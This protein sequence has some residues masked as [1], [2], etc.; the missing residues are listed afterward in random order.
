V[1]SCGG[2]SGNRMRTAD[3]DTITNA[4]CGV[5]Y[6]IGC[7]T[8]AFDS[9]SIAEAFVTNSHGGT[10]A[11]IGNS[12]YGWGSPG[13]PGFGYS[14]KFDNRFW[15]ALTS[16]GRYRVGDA[17]T[18]AKAYYAPFS[19]DKNVYRW[20]QYEVNLMGDP[21]MPVW[22]DL[23]QAL[24]VTAPYLVARGRSRYVVSVL[25]SGRPVHGAQVCLWEPGVVY[26]RALTDEAGVAALDLDASAASRMVLTVAARNCCP[27]EM[28]VTVGG[29]HVNFAGL[30]VDDSAGNGDG[31]A[32]PGEV[33]VMPVW[34]EN[35]GDTASLPMVASLVSRGPIAVVLDSL[36]SIGAIGP[37]DSL[38]IADAFRVRF[39]GSAR[40]GQ[41]ARFELFLAGGRGPEL[42]FPVVQVGEPKLSLDRAWL[43]QP[44][45]LP[46]ATRGLGIRLRNSGHGYGYDARCRL[47]SLDS[48]VAVA[49]DSAGYG[50]VRPLSTGG[51]T[52]SFAV[53]ASSFC[54]PGHVA[55]LELTTTAGAYV[56]VDTFP[57]LVGE[58]GFSDDMESGEA[59]W[60]H[61]GTGDRWHLTS[62]RAHSGASAWYC[63]DEGTRQ[64]SS[65]MDAWLETEPFVVTD[66]CTLKFWRWFKVPNYGVD[67]IRVVVVRAASE[68]TLDF[69]GTGGA[70]GDPAFTN[71]S[72]WAGESYDL[73][74]VGIGETIRVKLAFA[75]DRDTVDE[76]F[77]I[78]DVMVV[79][80]GPP[81]MGVAELEL[82][83]V[84]PLELSA[85]PNPFRGRVAVQ[86]AMPL[87]D[88]VTGRVF[89]ASGRMVR[90]F[91]VPAGHSAWRWDGLDA[92]GRRLPAGTYF[93]E[94]R[95][96]AASSVAR[97]VM[98]D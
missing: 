64:Y 14:D 13:N 33:A 37:G 22:T 75:S 3:A 9:N 4:A 48:L 31:I 40:D 56:W 30:R 60:S 98:T 43:L 68:E 16:E 81:V 97:L 91:L 29:S 63:G 53:E 66:D 42:F 95:T 35:P 93:V 72:Q 87:R 71:E 77:Y 19:H 46:G 96:G 49:A 26:C 85:R 54:P 36:A 94:A 28:D 90:S 67:G 92:R 15:Y 34:L 51:S 70:L 32:N 17:L 58:Y 86:L 73:S 50:D 2:G 11:T 79:G 44:P 80:G 6:S 8:A 23:P 57:L 18:A 12:S 55:Q 7:W 74:D 45:L 5:L 27:Y 83:S 61:G 1:M 25:V 89:D 41:V 52:D 59:K 10:V 69:V 84:R 47:A 24:T 20:H 21:E 38:L 39:S 82:P 65:N 76:G 78:D 62:Y 88:D